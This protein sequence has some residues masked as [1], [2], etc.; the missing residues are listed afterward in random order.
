MMILKARTFPPNVIAWLEL[1]QLDRDG[2]AVPV[3]GISVAFFDNRPAC[4]H[5]DD[6]FEGAKEPWSRGMV[7]NNN[8]EAPVGGR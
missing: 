3:D 1:H 6:A 2:T 4:L 5:V 8:L 7:E